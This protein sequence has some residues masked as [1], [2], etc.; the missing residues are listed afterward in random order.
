MTLFF[1]GPVDLRLRTFNDACS[2]TYIVRLV[3]FLKT[4]NTCILN[5]RWVIKSYSV[6]Q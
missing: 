3:E 6:I 2:S 4:K 5:A 1:P